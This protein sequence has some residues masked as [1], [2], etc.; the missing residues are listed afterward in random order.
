MQFSSVV[1]SRNQ[2][3]LSDS[4]GSNGTY[5]NNGGGAAYFNF[6]NA[7]MEATFTDVIF[8]D[9]FVNATNSIGLDTVNGGGAMYLV[10]EHGMLSLSGLLVGDNVALVDSASSASLTNNGGGGVLV[11]GKVSLSTNISDC[12]VEHNTL[13]AR[14]SLGLSVVSNGGGGIMLSSDALQFSVSGTTFANNSVEADYSTSGNTNFNGGGGLYA[15]STGTHAAATMSQCY[16]ILNRV[17]AVFNDASYSNLNG[18]GGLLLI[19]LSSGQVQFEG[20]NALYN[21]ANVSSASSQSVN[22]NGGAGMSLFHMHCGKWFL[23]ELYRRLG[24][25]AAEFERRS[26]ELHGS[27]QSD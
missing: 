22:N 1:L 5:Q 8:M 6:V 2:A 27:K 9:N 15:V 17:S 4:Y 24:D 25:Y 12:V 7:L 21:F 20:I 11:V 19:S 3:F 26:A 23:M 16:L 14:N 10:S 18:G 13:S